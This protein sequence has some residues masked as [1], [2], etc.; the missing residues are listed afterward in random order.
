MGPRANY[1]P[2]LS[3][4]PVKESAKYNGTSLK[5]SLLQ[6]E[7]QKSGVELPSVTQ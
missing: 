2:R 3:N 1:S 5:P 4:E 6:V 7:E